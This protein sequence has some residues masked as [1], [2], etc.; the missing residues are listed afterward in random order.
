M[1]SYTPEESNH[2]RFWWEKEEDDRGNGVCVKMSK[3]YYIYG[4]V[5]IKIGSGGMPMAPV[6]IET[7]EVAQG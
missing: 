2:N 5:K 6:S 1:S 4:T 7:S 3:I